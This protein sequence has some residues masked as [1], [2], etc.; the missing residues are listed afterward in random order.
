M[1]SSMSVGNSNDMRGDVQNIL[2]VQYENT[3]SRLRFR[4]FN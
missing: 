2:S 3:C 4:V 1:D